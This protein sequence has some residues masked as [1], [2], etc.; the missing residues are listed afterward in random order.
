M[1]PDL[2]ASVRL[3]SSVDAERSSADSVESGVRRAIG[4]SSAA[5]PEYSAYGAGS[6]EHHPKPK[7]SADGR[8]LHVF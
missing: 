7:I 2:R 4:P 8:L 3:D 5:G 6:H 1:R